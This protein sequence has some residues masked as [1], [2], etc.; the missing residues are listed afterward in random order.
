M[1]VLLSEKK[2]TVSAGCSQ[3][4]QDKRVGPDSELARRIFHVC[5]VT[6]FSLRRDLSPFSLISDFSNQN[7]CANVSKISVN[8]TDNIPYMAVHGKFEDDQMYEDLKIEGLNYNYRISR[9]PQSPCSSKASYGLD[10]LS[11]YIVNSISSQIGDQFMRKAEEFNSL[12][13][14]N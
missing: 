6:R 11:R 4:S 13:K 12:Q 7:A 9:K 5:P 8:H 14:R 2:L 1:K 10:S 3:L